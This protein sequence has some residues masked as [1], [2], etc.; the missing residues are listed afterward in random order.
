MDEKQWRK[1]WSR[2]F[3]ARANAIRAEAS[4]LPYDSDEAEAIRARAKA[5][6][7]CAIVLNA[8]PYSLDFL[9]SAL[10]RRPE[11]DVA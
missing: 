1:D 10:I 8:T 2:Y 9:R 3:S 11:S 6:D 5:I 7:E 4:G